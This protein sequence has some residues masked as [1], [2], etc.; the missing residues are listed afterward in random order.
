MKK[1]AA[2]ILMAS[3]MALSMG[4]CGS[5]SDAN[6]GSGNGKTACKDASDSSYYYYFEISDNDSG[7][8]KGKFK[9][10]TTSSPNAGDLTSRSG[11]SHWE[12]I[13]TSASSVGNLKLTYEIC[14]VAG[15]CI[16]KE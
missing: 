16:K 4:A 5:S 12:C 7:L 3:V 2:A 10:S 6:T 9:W 13:G 11:K 1:R 14:D 15:N 8:K